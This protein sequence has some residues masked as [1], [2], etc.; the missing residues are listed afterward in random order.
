MIL[1]THVCDT[2]HKAITEEI[3]L[4]AGQVEYVNMPQDWEDG[5]CPECQY[6][7]KLLA[8]HEAEMDKEL[9]D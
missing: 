9:F 6:E 7:A 4:E 2:C 1:L 3:R 8:E 5:I